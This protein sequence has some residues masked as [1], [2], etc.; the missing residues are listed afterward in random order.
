M[1]ADIVEV[2]GADLPAAAD[3][4]MI[5]GEFGLVEPH[6]EKA[7]EEARRFTQESIESVQGR[8][9][10]TH[11][12]FI[13]IDG[14][15]AR[16]FD[17]AVYVEADDKGFVLWVAIADVSHY[18]TKGSALDTDAFERGT[19][20]YFP[21]RAFHMLPSELSENL[22]SLKPGLPRLAL[23]AKIRISRSGE[24][25]ETK[26]FESVIKSRRRA[27]YNEIEREKADFP[28]H[29]ELFRLLRETRIKRGAIDF[30]L[31]EAKARLDEKGEP[32]KIVVLGR[33]EL[34]PVVGVPPLGVGAEVPVVVRL[35]QAARQAELPVPLDAPLGGEERQHLLPDGQGHVLGPQEA[36]VAQGVVLVGDH[37]V[38]REG[39][40]DVVA[41]VFEGRFVGLGVEV[42]GADDVAT[43]DPVLLAEAQ[44]GG[45]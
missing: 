12:P 32:V 33:S 26:L 8:T 43:A 41:H 38:A 22:C 25:T 28:L 24:R 29:Y 21:E 16:D 27:T 4:P 44:P 6:P 30:D 23:T 39:V 18:V 3:L 2:Y 35:L 45:V 14:E 11:I 5:A 36:A 15:D 40:G 13:T 1:I 34:V 7:I 17:D 31:P 20:V 10:L 9:D 19:S 37:R 42:P